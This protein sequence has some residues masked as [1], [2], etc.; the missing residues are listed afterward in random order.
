MINRQEIFNLIKSKALAQ[1][2]KCGIIYDKDIIETKYY[3]NGLR[4]HIGWIIP[5]NEY[6]PEFEGEN[7]ASESKVGKYFL[8]K[9]YSEED[10]DFLHKFQVMHDDINV[11]DWN[12]SFDDIA[13]NY[14]LNK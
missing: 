9:G 3:Y 11:E 5:E 12:S 2:Q 13:L 4:C 10:L 8:S 14:G 1:N 6:L 7:L